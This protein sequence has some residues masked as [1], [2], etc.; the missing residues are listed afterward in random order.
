MTSFFDN[1]VITSHGQLVSLEQGVQTLRSPMGV[2]LP[3]NQTRLY[4]LCL[5]SSSNF[6]KAL[7]VFVNLLLDVSL[8]VFQNQDSCVPFLQ[9]S[10]NLLIGF[11]ASVNN[12]DENIFQI[13]NFKYFAK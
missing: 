11:G 12:K 8:C 6:L 5:Y 3:P 4:L 1:I 7:I 9:L 13:D 10:T 2:I